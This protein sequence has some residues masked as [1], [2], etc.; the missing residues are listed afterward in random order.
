MGRGPSPDVGQAKGV[1]GVRL[2]NMLDTG[3]TKVRYNMTE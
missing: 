2:P 3:W 1:G